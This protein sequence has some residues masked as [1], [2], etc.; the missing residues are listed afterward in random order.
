MRKTILGICFISLFLIACEQEHNKESGFTPPIGPYGLPY[1]VGN[2]GGKPVNLGE[3]I[4]FLEYED[5]RF[6]D[7]DKKNTHYDYNSKIIV[8]GFHFRYT[9][10]LFLVKYY[11][12]PQKA[13]EY[14]KVEYFL[15]DNKWV[16]VG[17]FSNKIHHG[18]LTSYFL[19]S[20][21]DSKIIPKEDMEK[22]DYMNIYVSANET[23]YGLEKY[24]PH[25][26]W[27][28]R[29]NR[30]KIINRN[31]NKYNIDDLYVEKNKNG[32]VVTFTECSTINTPLARRCKQYFLLEPY[33]KARV[34]TTF[35]RVHLKDWKLIKK[36]ATKIIK[37]FVVK[38]K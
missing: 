4:E 37:S 20:T 34:S 14:Y 18:D 2:L 19:N 11:K 7:K 30:L 38:S 23:Q 26:R 29:N 31:L 16:D 32:K 27:V 24:V 13:Y 1:R 28:E 22:F 3:G 17:V 6:F 8:F 33:M 21:L 36:G 25:P 9:D 12:A 10:D 35:Q 5:F 15:P